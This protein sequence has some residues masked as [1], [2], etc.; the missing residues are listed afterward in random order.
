MTQDQEISFDDL[1]SYRTFLPKITQEIFDF[2]GSEKVQLIEVLP[3]GKWN[4]TQEAVDFCAIIPV[5][6]EQTK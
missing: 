5:N 2:I 4:W 3:D 1:G 6:Q